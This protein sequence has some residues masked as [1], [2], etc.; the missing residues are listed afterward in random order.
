MSASDAVHSLFSFPG[1]F[2]RP[3]HATTAFFHVGPQKT[4]SQKRAI[5]AYEPALFNP[6]LVMNL[7]YKATHQENRTLPFPP[8]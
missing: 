2:L 4:A 5:A 8:G 6:P 1:M 3:A 7:R